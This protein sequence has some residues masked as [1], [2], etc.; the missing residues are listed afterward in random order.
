MK[1]LNSEMVESV[2]L[3]SGGWESFYY[4]SMPACHHAITRPFLTPRLSCAILVR[5]LF[6]AF[7][8]REAAEA[9]KRAAEG[10]GG[11][12]TKSKPE[13]KREMRRRRRAQ[14]YDVAMV[15]RFTILV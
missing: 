6:A 7:L 4:A 13:S 11:E 10:G 12:A 2:D 9:A 15:H 8:I 1:L 5:H 14:R 3:T